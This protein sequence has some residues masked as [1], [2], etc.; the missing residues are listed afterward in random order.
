M[1]LNKIYDK[2]KYE[3]TRKVN[4]TIKSGAVWVSTVELNGL[5]DFEGIAEEYFGQSKEWMDGKIEGCTYMRESQEFTG[6]EYAKLAEA[7]RD[8]ARRLSKAADEIDAAAMRDADIPAE[9]A[10]ELNKEFNELLHGKH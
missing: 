8:I 1:D 2:E 7:Y 4:V 3:K 9:K 5:I 10:A 6:E